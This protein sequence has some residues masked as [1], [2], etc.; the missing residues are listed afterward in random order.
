MSLTTGQNKL[1]SLRRR[2]R[3]ESFVYCLL[4][5]LSVSLLATALLHILLGWP[6]WTGLPVLA[7]CFFP[8]LFFF[9]FWRVTVSDVARF[10]NKQVPELEESCELLLRSA[11][12]LG[13]LEK[14][15]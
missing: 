9:P 11:D 8:V 12:E 4:L 7:G 1:L 13:P 2:W 14:L 5:S 10:L 6:L 3:A 15:Q